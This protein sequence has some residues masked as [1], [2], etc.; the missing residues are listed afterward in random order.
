MNTPGPATW[1]A[2]A[3]FELRDPLL[4]TDAPRLRSFPGDHPADPL[5]S[6]ERRN[7]F[8]R[9]PRRGSSSNRLS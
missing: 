3:T 4:D 7:V 6:R 1:P 5:I 9:C 8:P 2:H